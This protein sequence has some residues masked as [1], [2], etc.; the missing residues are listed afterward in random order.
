M[1]AGNT[2][3]RALAKS[4]P[5]TKQSSIAINSGIPSG[6]F[7]M[8]HSSESGLLPQRSAKP[9]RTASTPA[10][11]RRWSLVSSAE[12]PLGNLFEE[13]AQQC[14]SLID[15]ELA[16]VHLVPVYESFSGLLDFPEGLLF[17]VGTVH[18][19]ICPSNRRR[20]QELESR[21]Q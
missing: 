10:S 21:S 4:S 3:E 20:S 1:A 2:G 18:P 12:S 14:L 13:C 8:E 17:W 15:R 19:E 7:A 16:F 5:E 9:L 11:T 6:L